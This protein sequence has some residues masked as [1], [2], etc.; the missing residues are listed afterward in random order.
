MKLFS[1][2]LSVIVFFITLYF[3][4]LKIPYVETFD[5]TIYISLMCIL[6]VICI[7]GVLINMEIFR[8]AK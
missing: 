1:F 5:D 4:V 2:I 7:L 8:N 3:F 6:M